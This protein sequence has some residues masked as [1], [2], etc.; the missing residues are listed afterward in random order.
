MRVGDLEIDA[1]AEP[2]GRLEA[3]ME[4]AVEPL[5]EARGILEKGCEDTISRKLAENNENNSNQTRR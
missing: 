5:E 3:E 2:E 4:R 1:Q